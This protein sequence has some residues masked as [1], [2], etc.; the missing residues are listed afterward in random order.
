MNAII[1]S[2]IFDR[3]EHEVLSEPFIILVYGLLQNLDA[4]R[5]L[6]E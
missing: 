2:A 1:T 4:P 6:S 3:Y 5:S